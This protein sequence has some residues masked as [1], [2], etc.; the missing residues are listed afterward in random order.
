MT[1]VA[2]VN[3][4]VDSWTTTPKA[5]TAGSSLGF[6]DYVWCLSFLAGPKSNKSTLIQC[7]QHL[8]L[9]SLYQINKKLSTLHY[10]S[11]I[12]VGIVDFDGRLPCRPSN[13]PHNHGGAVCRNSGMDVAN[14]PTPSP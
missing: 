12:H 4:E 10:C 8:F 14:Q 6:E 13:K 9:L 2:E 1:P 11:L 3:L 7:L 5:T